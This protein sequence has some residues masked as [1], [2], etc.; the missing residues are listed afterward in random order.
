M[1]KCEIDAAFFHLYD[2]N[3]DDIVYVMN[4]FGIVRKNDE[5]EFGYYRSRDVIIEIYDKLKKSI[6]AGG[7][8]ETVVSNS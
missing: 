7:K 5:S 2:Y 1:I 6:L 4:S 3:R 8:Y